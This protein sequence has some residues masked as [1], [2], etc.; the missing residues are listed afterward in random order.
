VNV[1][2][3]SGIVIVG[4]TSISETVTRNCDVRDRI[5][6]LATTTT[7]TSVFGAGLQNAAVSPGSPYCDVAFGV[8]PQLRG[9][10]AY[11]VPKIDVQLAVVF[12]SK[13]G[14]MLVANYAAPNAETAPSLG[15]PLSGNAAN[16]TVNLVEP[17]TSYGERINQFDVRAA[18]LLKAGR[19]RAIVAVEVYN[20]LN[21]SAP[22]AYNTSFVRAATWPQ[23]LTIL[24]PRFLKLS[25]EIEF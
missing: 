17:G 5:P 9:M 13:P 11:T 1:R 19:S 24:T 23:P 6:E 3:P 8:L 14:P 12:Q 10:S 2:T 18:K 25:A 20:A 22:L 7:G 4:G 15:R 21:S 16:F